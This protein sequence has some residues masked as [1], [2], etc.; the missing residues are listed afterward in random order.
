MK[1]ATFSRGGARHAGPPPM[2]AAAGPQ[3]GTRRHAAS[4]APAGAGMG[5]NVPARPENTGAPRTA[6]H[7]PG[8]PEHPLK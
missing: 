7:H 5:T 3:A 4:G 6:V 8:I 2:D 1:I